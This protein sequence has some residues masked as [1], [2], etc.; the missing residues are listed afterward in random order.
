MNCKTSLDSVK[1][2]VKIL[3]PEDKVLNV[4]KD[5]DGYFIVV[6]KGNGE[7]IIYSVKLDEHKNP[8]LDK[9]HPLTITYGTGSVEASFIQEEEEIKVITA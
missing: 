2:T 3:E 4:W 5:S 6:Q 8:R 1:L 7:V 9:A